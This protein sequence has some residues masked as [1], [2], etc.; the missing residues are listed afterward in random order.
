MVLGAS[1]E[2]GGPEVTSALN[3]SAVFLRNLMGLGEAELCWMGR[4]KDSC[5]P[6]VDPY[7]PRCQSI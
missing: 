3:S 5:A 2:G 7:G 6:L 1:P 4:Q